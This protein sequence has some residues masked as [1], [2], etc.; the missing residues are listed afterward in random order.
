MSRWRVLSSRYALKL[1]FFGLR[2]DRV[3]TGRGVVMDDYPIIESR[4]WACVVCLDEQGRAVMVE[5]YRHGAQAITLEFVAGGIDAGEDPLHAAQRELLEETGYE[6]P[7]WHLLKRLSPDSTRHR[8]KVHIYLAT[9]ARATGPQQ[10]E[11]NEDVTVV[12]RDLRAPAMREE[13]IHA[14]HVLA[15]LLAVERLDG[16]ERKHTL[17]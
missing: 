16:T 8:N 5:Q 10:L 3:E 12:L 6:A 14:I 13:L 2:V 7:H 17:D 9:G 15:C 1:P 4:D 11:E